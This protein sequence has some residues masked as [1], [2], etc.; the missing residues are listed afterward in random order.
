MDLSTKGTLFFPKKHFMM[1]SHLVILDP[2]ARIQKNVAQTCHK[3]HV[4]QSYLS[5]S[6][7]KLEKAQGFMHQ[8][9]LKKLEETVN[10]TVSKENWIKVDFNEDRMTQ[11]NM[12]S[13]SILPVAHCISLKDNKNKS[14]F[15]SSCGQK[16]QKRELSNQWSNPV[17][18]M[19]QGDKSIR[20][21]DFLENKEIPDFKMAS[22]M[23]G[24]AKSLK[25]K[26][27]EKFIHSNTT[28][29]KT[30]QAEMKK[31]FTQEELK[32]EERLKEKKKRDILVQLE[33]SKSF[34][35][36]R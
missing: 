19:S 12:L 29:P 33:N 7:H 6:L 9:L 27:E 2:V 17:E 15:L 30:K 24:A 32:D 1:Y 16:H 25:L 34:N 23:D 36:N 35:I 11:K 22:L 28:S 5:E 4:I 21:R 18:V 31:A 10:K 26:S 20:P 3:F 14:L 8:K 13:Q